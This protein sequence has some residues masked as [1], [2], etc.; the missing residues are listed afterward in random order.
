MKMPLVSVH[1][2]IA[3]C[4]TLPDSKKAQYLFEAMDVLQDCHSPQKIPVH[5]SHNRA[6]W[7]MGLDP[8]QWPVP[9]DKGSPSIFDIV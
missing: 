7:T 1:I 5:Y 6:T 8:I 4:I 2:Q 3:I 9:K